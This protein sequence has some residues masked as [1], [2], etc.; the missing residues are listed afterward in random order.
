MQLEDLR[1][2][3]RVR[4]LVPG[5]AVRVI[6]VTRV[7]ADALHIVFGRDDGSVDQ[8]MLMRATESQL[9]AIEDR[10]T[11]FDAD[12]DEFKL[13]AEALRIRLAASETVGQ[14]GPYRA[15]P[16]Q[17]E[18]VYRHLLDRIPLRFLLAD[19]PGAGKTIMAGLFLKELQLRGG[20]DR[21]LIIAPG[22][23][24]EQWQDEL[25]SKFG[26]DFEVLAVEDIRHMISGGALFDRQTHLVAR[27]DQVARNDDLIGVFSRTPWDVV[28]VDEAHRMS[29]HYGARREVKPTKRYRLGIALREAAK[30]F[31]L[32]T[33]TPHAGKEED[34]QLFMRLLDA[35]RFEGRYRHGVH[36]TGADGL[37]L[38]R[39]KEELLTLEGRQLFTQRAAYTV[40]YALSADE[41][42]LYEDV[43]AYVRDEFDRADSLDRQQRN[44]VGFA[45]TVLQRRLA[46]SPHAILVS[47]ERRLERL[48]AALVDSESSRPRRTRRPIV[49]LEAVAEEFPAGEREE[50][51]DEVAVATTA[52][53]TPEEL[54]REIA[55]LDSL[56][57]KARQLRS[58]GADRKWFELRRLFE[59]SP[60][61]RDADGNIRKIIVFTEHRDTLS[62]LIERTR[63]LL[64]KR[65]VV[66]SIH[67]G[68]SRDQRLSAQRRFT[69]DPLCRVL[70]ATDAA[71]E[72]LNLQ[73]AHLM[74]NYD[75]PWNP[76]RLEQRFG[77]IHRIG[78]EHMC[79]L[80]NVV[81]GETREGAVYLRLLQKLDEMK[82]ALGGKVF[83]VLGQVFEDAPLH[84]LL[85]EAVRHGDDPEVRQHLQRIIDERVGDVARRLVEERA[86]APEVYQPVAHG[87]Y[88]RQVQEA[89][90]RRLQPHYVEAFFRD[91]FGRAGGTLTRREPGRWEI[92]HI[93][94]VLRDFSRGALAAVR[95]PR[96]CFDP[97]MEESGDLPKA[98]V[99]GPGR[100]LFDLVL[101]YIEATYA[102]ALDRG[103]VLVDRLD[104]STRPRL[105]AAIQNEIVDGGGVQVQRRFGFVEIDEGGGSRTGAARFLDYDA[106]SPSERALLIDLLKQPWLAQARHT[107]EA[108]ATNFQLQPW[109]AEVNEHR[110]AQVARARE[111]VTDR[112]KQEIAYW[113]E[114]AAKAESGNDAGG[115][116]PA[117]RAAWAEVRRLQTA[118][119]RRL[120]ELE[121]QEYTRV[122]PPRV[123]AVALV[124]PQGLLDQMEGRPIVDTYEVEVRAMQAVNAAER[125]LGR[126]PQ[127]MDHNNP[128]FDITSSDE[129]N[130]QLVFIE[131]KGRIEGAEDFFVT[132]HEIR[133]GQNTGSQYRLALVEV[134]PLG[135]AHDLVRYVENPFD[136]VNV[137]S[138]VKGVQFSWP[139]TWASGRDPW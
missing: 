6:A 44:N 9:V 103:T 71:G 31:L 119:D 67:G 69:T 50:F 20:L 56:V 68:L 122:N 23:L 18:A 43:T 16:H 61:I 118:L 45:L 17:L 94:S 38:R 95:F 72:G 10:P 66:A 37:M 34:F 125:A 123:L 77:R 139:K 102:D 19:D 4:G 115:R 8:Q 120:G 29:A 13:A 89:R 129:S 42:A 30:H 100:P 58:S 112:L 59:A 86:L 26:L 132:N 96:V 57:A 137:P 90:A 97:A 74:V 40:P 108:W 92:P 14:D 130:G 35:D 114:H 39:T 47:L 63:E 126:V 110:R 48:R 51:E 127:A 78:Q 109:Y 101:R 135:P 79:H 83:D 25:R 91:A 54:K 22:G 36:A 11:P 24:V 52:A 113:E 1:P 82:K 2:G 88:Q 5:G 124:A 87:P 12:A 121:S 81:A 105:L 33:A 65:G 49:D 64:G 111:L 85:L 80:W 41:R 73:A 84:K 133:H 131:V 98:E 70:I 136:E 53:R 3:L 55:V 134:S 27:M 32:M 138:L 107:A 46:S 99:L 62:Y 76:N 117:V 106:G 7:G 21:C 93:P 15:L 104:S 116:G 128:G 28:I 75:L 60:E